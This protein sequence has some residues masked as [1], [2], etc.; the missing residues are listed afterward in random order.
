MRNV[1]ESPAKSR[2][3]STHGARQS[4]L[5]WLPRSDRGSGGAEASI[6]EEELMTGRHTLLWSTTEK[7]MTGRGYKGP[8]RRMGG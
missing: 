4:M 8:T 5:W 7:L 1:E 2:E 3:I 6:S